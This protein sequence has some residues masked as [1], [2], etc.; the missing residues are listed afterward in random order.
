M[1]L[2]DLKART[3]RLLN[4]ADAA[5]FKNDINAIQ[6]I[7]AT[8]QSG[9]ADMQAKARVLLSAITAIKKDNYFTQLQDAR[10]RLLL[11]IIIDDQ[12]ISGKDIEKLIQNKIEKP[13]AVENSYLDEYEQSLIRFLE[14]SPELR[15][16][17]DEDLK[18]ISL[19][20]QDNVEE[21]I[22]IDVEPDEEVEP[23]LFK[24]NGKKKFLGTQGLASCLAIAVIAKTKKNN[25]LASL[26]HLVMFDAE[27]IEEKISELGSYKIQPESVQV[28]IAGG[29]IGDFHD[30]LDLIS[31]LI[32]KKV[33]CVYHM[34]L[35]DS[36][37]GDGGAALLITNA[38]DGSA[39]VSYSFAETIKPNL[40]AAASSQVAASSQA[41]SSS[42]A[43]ASPHVYAK[44][45]SDKKRDVDTLFSRNKGEELNDDDI[46]KSA[47]E[48]MATAAKKKKQ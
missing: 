22:E 4:A 29:C 42:Q 23:V 47:A 11:K 20:R 35:S 24:V 28:Y 40:Q 10:S 5:K 46:S 38:D 17:Y 36:E 3:C 7:M 9:F 32:D 8:D 13:E 16:K 19:V 41:A 44:N 14:K 18:S 31:D 37:A 21:R 2:A 43:A 6:Q 15:K 33:P 34:G 45:K 27:M 25:T 12:T 48:S 39:V 1:N 26:E 30:C